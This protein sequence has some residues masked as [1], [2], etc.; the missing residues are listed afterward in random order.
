M[1]PKVLVVKC[2]ARVS[3]L[4]RSIGKVLL[5][6][7]ALHATLLN[8]CMSL[9]TAIAITVVVPPLGAVLVVVA[10]AVIVTLAHARHHSLHAARHPVGVVL[11]V[12][13]LGA[14]DQ[15]AL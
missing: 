13:N 2:T 5:L 11:A 8:V 7:S 14:T 15:S 4:E 1:A 10:P 9:T 12:E 3:I 6:A